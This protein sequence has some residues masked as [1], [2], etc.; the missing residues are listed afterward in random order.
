MMGIKTYLDRK[1]SIYPLITYRILFGIMMMVSTARFIYLG[2]IEDQYIDPSF[3]FSYYGFEWIK[4]LGFAGMYIVFIVMFLAAIAVTLGWRYRLSVFILFLAFTYVELIDLSYY[5]NHYYFVSMMLL[6]FN[7]LPLHKAVSLD[8]RSDE[9]RF[10]S[11]VPAWM[12]HSVMLMI[13]IVYTYA[14]FAKMNYT[15]LMEA[16]PLKIWLPAHDDMPIIGP[17][18]KYETTAY[19]FSWFGMLYDTFVV[20]FLLFPRTRK[21]AFLSVIIF[22]TLTGMLFQ[23][24]VFPLVMICS[25][26]IFFSKRWHKKL[27]YKLCSIVDQWHIPYFNRVGT[28]EKR[29]RHK[30]IIPVLTVF[31][32]FQILF[33][34]RYLLYSG[35]LFWTEEGYR[36]SW[37]VML[38]EKS[39]SATFYVKDGANGREG[40]VFNSQ[41]LNDHQ[42]KQMA[43]QPDMILQYAHHL[44]KYY[45]EKGLKDP[46]VRVEAYVTLNGAPSKL[47]ID[48]DV[49]LMTVTDT[50]K[51]KTWVLEE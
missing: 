51:H 28:L 29:P 47:L 46:Q 22:H 7:I 20:V 25:A 32:V 13:A 19:L 24:G 14:G 35:N 34:F 5:L 8:V 31:F 39:G 9:T 36:F 23:I 50:W 21:L 41:F 48:P 11:E 16:L 15:W 45:K 49:N 10:V 43:M 37:R 27:L 26:S 17:L 30:Y 18:F 40:Q 4:P 33:P 42:E 1:T 2:W 12:L 38:M 6:L 3:H 44:G